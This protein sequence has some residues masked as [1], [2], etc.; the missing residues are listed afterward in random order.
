M[1]GMSPHRC[2]AECGRP[3]PWKRF[4]CAEDWDRLP[5]EMQAEIW[6]TWRARRRDPAAHYRAMLTAINWYRAHPIRTG[7]RS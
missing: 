5:G 3:V 2:P 1:A 4:A 6:R 7:V